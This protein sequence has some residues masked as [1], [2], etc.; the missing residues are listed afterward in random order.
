MSTATGAYEPRGAARLAE[1][2]GAWLLALL[3]ILPLVYAAWAAFHAPEFSARFSL[4]APWTRR[5]PGISS[6]PSCW[7]R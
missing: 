4:A 3:W 7:S 1:T 5:S 6:I 2:A